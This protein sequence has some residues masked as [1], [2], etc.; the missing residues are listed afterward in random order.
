MMGEINDV[1][2]NL[3]GITQN[4]AQTDLN[5]MLENVNDLV[6]QS[7]ESMADAMTKIDA[8]DV[9]ALNDAIVDLGKIVAP[10]AKLF[11]K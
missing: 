11:G 7:E 1:M 6:V 9:D 4:L 5:S 2:V 8:I 3:D 10:L